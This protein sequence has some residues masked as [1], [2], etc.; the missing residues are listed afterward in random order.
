M[1]NARQA[2]TAREKSAALQAEAAAKARQRRVVVVAATVISAIVVIVGASVLIRAAQQESEQKAAVN[3]PANITD[4]AFVDGEASAPVTIRVYSDFLCPVCRQFEEQ[5]AGQIAA[6]VAEGKV[7]VEY[8]PIAILDRLSSD[9]YP[10]RA[11]SAA[12]A[13]ADAAPSSWVAFHKLL[14]ENQPAENGPGL[15]DDQLVEL[16]VRAGAEEAAVRPNIES[17]KFAGFARKQTEAATSGPDKV[18]GTPTVLVN[19]ELLKNWSADQVKAAV[20][21]AAAR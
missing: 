18:T 9:E 21:A 1:T 13:V 19:G 14:F 11:A 10:T 5:N 2:R 17:Q 4:G 15:T 16:A 7:K 6:W 3:T 20:E 12:F 8:K